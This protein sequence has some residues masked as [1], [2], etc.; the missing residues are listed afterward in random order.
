MALIFSAAISSAAY[1]A[2]TGITSLS[3]S[4]TEDRADPGTVNQAEVQVNNSNVNVEVSEPSRDYGDWRPGSK[5]TW[6]VVLVPEEGYS[7]VPVKL[8]KVDVQNGETVSSTIGAK[9]ITMKINYLPKVTLESPQN[10]YFEDDNTAKW[11]KVPY[12]EMYE[13]QIFKE[14]DDGNYVSYKTVKI[15]QAKID[16]SQYV[17]DGSDAYFKVRAVPKSS[18]QSAYLKSSEWTDS[19]DVSA[20]SD[21][22]VNGNFSGSGPSMTF[23]DL[24]GVKASGWQKISG[25]WYYFDPQNNQQAVSSAWSLIN[26]K[27]Y[28][29][30]DYGI[31]V[32]GWVKVNDTWYF[33]N[34]DGV[35]QTGWYQDGPGGAWYYLDPGNG[36][37]W[38]SA[39]TPDGYS[40]DASGAWYS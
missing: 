37:L 38:V 40:V 28:Y 15:P 8:K 22:T 23:T 19:N 30:N 32:T 13:V 12:C 17:T 2:G 29:F 20:P 7:F 26:G 31:M 3:V 36:A 11:D 27:W 33:L 35:M 5:I 16:L 4:F 24:S 18:A 34:S 21:N 25:K 10:I 39:T 1:A 14:N 6:K 9:R